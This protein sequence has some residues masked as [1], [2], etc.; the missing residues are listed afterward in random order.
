MGVGSTK[1]ASQTADLY[2]Q[3]QSAEKEARRRIDQLQDQVKRT[4]QDLKDQLETVRDAYEKQIETEIVRNE[5]YLTQ[6]R[7]RAQEQQV[8]QSNAIRH[9]VQALQRRGERNLHELESQ[10]KDQNAAAERYGQES[11]KSA[12]EKYE[13]LK[14]HESR[15]QDQDLTNL[16]TSH[17]MNMANARERQATQVEKFH[18]DHAVE[19]DRL[20]TQYQQSVEKTEKD[21]DSAHQRIADEN[22]RALDHMEQSASEKLKDIR[23]D[24]AYRL[25]A[26]QSRQRDPF[27]R[28]LDLDLGVS[29]HA[30]GFVVTANIPQHEQEH[31]AVNVRGNEVVVSGRR[32]NQETLESPDGHKTQTSNYQYFMEAVPLGFPVEERGL[33]REFD[34]DRLTVFIPKK[35]FTRAHDTPYQAPSKAKPEKSRAERPQFPSNIPDYREPKN[36]IKS[37]A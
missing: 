10:Y 18:R 25:A 15:N 16:R 28:M 23:A 33:V 6:L 12:V 21:F 9:D 17:E 35:S 3:Q 26:Y 36:S 11:L 8:D 31:V 7:E 14:N 27:Y 30:D 19:V 37:K 32:S 2:R 13:T 24:T 20:K 5:S 4:E 34:G 29:E 22:H 1:S